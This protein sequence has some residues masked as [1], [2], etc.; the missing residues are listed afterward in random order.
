M[1][2]ADGIRHELISVASELRRHA[3]VDV[4]L[5][6][7]DQQRHLFTE[8]EQ[9]T[10]RY[11]CA[12]AIGMPLLPPENPVA[13]LLLPPSTSPSLTVPELSDPY[14]PSTGELI[15]SALTIT[16]SEAPSGEGL[17]EAIESIFS[18][19]ESPDDKSLEAASAYVSNK[20]SAIN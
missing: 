4:I 15:Q 9:A 8:D 3:A 19:Q 6:A 5:G 10:L 13:G 1:R 12:R 11:I 16:K 2:D 7:L 14:D 18:V 20:L 17:A